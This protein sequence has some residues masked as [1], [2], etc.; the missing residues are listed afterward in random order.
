MEFLL[1]SFRIPS[2]API[3]LTSAKVPVS[4]STEWS[5]KGKLFLIFFCF[6]LLR[7]VHACMPEC[8]HEF[9]TIFKEETKGTYWKK[10]KTRKKSSGDLLPVPATNL[11]TCSV[12]TFTRNWIKE[13]LQKA[14]WLP[15]TIFT[16]FHFAR[17]REFWRMETKVGI[18]FS[19]LFQ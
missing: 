6:P 19:S 13:W 12:L 4:K 11:N 3:F 15:Y 2:L 14:G 5:H 10:E 7:S 16:R 8:S 17:K 1:D 18:M 9:Q